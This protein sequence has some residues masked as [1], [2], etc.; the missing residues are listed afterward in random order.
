MD[1]VVVSPIRMVSRSSDVSKLGAAPA[2]QASKS[3][4]A[5][6]SALHAQRAQ[7]LFPRGILTISKTMERY[8][9]S[10]CGKIPEIGGKMNSK[11]APRQHPMVRPLANAIT[12]RQKDFGGVHDIV[13]Y[14][15]GRNAAGNLHD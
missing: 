14:L 10:L 7:P 8:V 2:G 13:R 11:A 6:P 15:V 3:H 12:K 4:P 1:K 9:C 5:S